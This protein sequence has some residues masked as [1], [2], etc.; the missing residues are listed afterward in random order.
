MEIERVYDG[1]G[2]QSR[3]NNTENYPNYQPQQQER[4]SSPYFAGH[5]PN[6]NQ[7]NQGY[8]N[9]PPFMSQPQNLN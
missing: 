6:H 8:Q 2:A 7:Q 9:M 4:S 1:E 5:Q 3:N